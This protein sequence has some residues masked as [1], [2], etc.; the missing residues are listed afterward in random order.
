MERAEE[1]AAD[2]S[3]E[4][5]RRRDHRQHEADPGP[6][7]DA[8]LAELVGLD[9]ALVVEGED[10]DRVECDVAVALVPGLQRLDGIVGGRLVLEERE[11]D[12]LT[13]HGFAL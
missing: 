11:D 7:A 6:F 2:D 10:A 8:A 4:Q 9:L 12:C 1:S 5:G 13:G 3:R